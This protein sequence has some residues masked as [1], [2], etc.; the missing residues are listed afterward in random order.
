M[1]FGLG[2]FATAGAGAAGSFDLLETQV[3]GST[4]ASVTFSSLGTYSNYKHLQIRMVARHTSSNGYGLSEVDLQFNSD[5]TTNYSIH[6]LLGDGGSV[7]SYGAANTSSARVGYF[8]SANAT[9]GAF[10]A[11]VIDILDAFDTKYT[12]IRSLTGAHSGYN[13][14]DPDQAV[15]LFSNSWRNTNAVSSIT[16]FRTGLS[17]AQYSRFSLYGLKG[18]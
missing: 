10:G 14:I 16:L 18:S 3:L 2:F 4:T 9:S 13:G 17:F 7:T 11:T 5:T 1:P 12:T 8:T 6:G 15:A